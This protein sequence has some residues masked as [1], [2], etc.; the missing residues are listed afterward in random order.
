MSDD[1]DR[2]STYNSEFVP[3]VFSLQNN[4][5]LCYLNSLIQ[6]LLSCPSFTEYLISNRDVY[7]EKK[8]EQGQIIQSFN[9]IVDEYLKLYEKHLFKNSGSK[10]QHPKTD[11]A[12]PILRELNNLRRVSGSK[13]H[14]SLNRQEDIHEGLTLILDSIGGDVENL[15]HCRYRC[16]LKCRACGKRSFP[17]NDPNHIEPPEIFI[18]LSEENPHIQDN[19]N[20]KEQIENYIKRNIQIPEDYKCENCGAVNTTDPKTGEVEENIIQIYSLARLSEIIVLLFKKYKKKR[21]IYF[22]PILEFKAMTGNL[23]YRIVSQVEHSG[24]MSGGHYIAKCLRLK[25]VQLHEFRKKKAEEMLA[26]IEK[27]MSSLSVTESETTNTKRLKKIK[28]TRQEYQ[29]RAKDIKDG[30][31]SDEISKNNPDAVF[32]FNDES[33]KYSPEGFEP[34]PNTYMVFYHLFDE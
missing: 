11:N 2:L 25:P 18:D 31:M 29:E 30:I 34:T 27:K 8:N 12:F 4:S 21:T 16:E 20:T 6:S 32:L 14:L 9:K 3:Q 19:L 15:F 23:K 22:P 33:T 26:V 10:F 13:Y 7:I 28:E 24:S 1:E 5:V 17:G